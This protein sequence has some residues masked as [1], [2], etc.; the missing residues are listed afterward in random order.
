MTLPVIVIGAG[1]HAKVVIEA[2]NLRNIPVLG[3]V[4]PDP[5][6]KT[7]MILGIS[8]LGSDDEV[9]RRDPKEI[10]L[11][12]G[13]G[14]IGITER[15]RAIYERFSEAGYRFAVVTHPS[16]VVATEVLLKEGAQVMAGAVI[17]P[18]C[19]IGRNSIVNTRV[20]VD[21][22]CEVGDHVHIAPG[23]VLS[24]CVQVGD[25][26]H[27]GTGTSVIQGIRIGNHAM[28]GAGAVVI[29]DVPDGVLAV[30]V[31]AKVRPK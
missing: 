26:A 13:V 31:P 6:S 14:S 16:A 3:I 30:G 9:F 22:D 20:S 1:G 23:S 11:V 4:D 5:L 19:R 2:L 15:R 17:Q 25:G 7:K 24:G 28:V 29:R 27:I 21:H 10:L 8:V 12:N 18:G